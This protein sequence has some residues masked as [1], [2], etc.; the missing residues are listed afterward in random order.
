LL[1]LQ[2]LELL[3][4]QLSCFDTAA[5]VAAA[6]E[7]PF[8]DDVKC[9]EPLFAALG[10]NR[11]IANTLVRAALTSAHALVPTFKGEHDTGADSAAP[12]LHD[13]A[14]Q[15]ILLYA[16]SELGTYNTT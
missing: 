16:A 3:Q 4:A 7:R 12:N 13:H 5:K 14:L 10:A 1:C 6:A 2:A 15:S 8:A 9:L 11:T